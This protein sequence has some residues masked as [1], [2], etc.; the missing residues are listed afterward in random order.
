MSY[1]SW[2]ETCRVIQQ[3]FWGPKYTLTPSIYFQGVRTPSTP[4]IYAPAAGN[5]SLASCLSRSLKV[6]GNDMDRSANRIH[7]RGSVGD[8]LSPVC[9]WTGHQMSQFNDFK[10]AD[11]LMCDQR[12]LI[13][14]VMIRITIRIGLEMTYTV[15]SGTLNN[16]IPYHTG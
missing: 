15:S 6:I 11:G 13:R 16:S 14:M 5:G 4:K 12:Q 1:P 3:Q 9:L 8:K 7:N 10:W 2:C